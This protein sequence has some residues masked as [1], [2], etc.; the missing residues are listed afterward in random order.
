MHM[1]SKLKNKCSLLGS[2]FIILGVIV[3]ISALSLT[4]Y[5]V[6]DSLR[7]ERDSQIIVSYIRSVRP[8]PKEYDAGSD[9]PNTEQGVQDAVVPDYVLNPDM[10]MPV[11]EYEGRNYIGTLTI[12]SLEVELPVLEEW[13]Y[14]GLKI[15]PCRYVNTPYKKNFVIAAH[16]YDSHFGRINELGQGDE[17]YF[18]DNDGNVFKY[19]VS[20]VDT[21]SPYAVDEMKSGDW[22]LTLFTCTI[23]G[24][25]RV[26]VRCVS[27]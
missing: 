4:C 24:R 26:T 16:N 19:G 14:P 18:T 17:V 11:I 2:I 25:L 7:A 21:L 20:I 15:S 22:D 13:S 6:Y 1:N 5:N 3:L 10:D 23:G 8:A 27:I 9:V 12:P